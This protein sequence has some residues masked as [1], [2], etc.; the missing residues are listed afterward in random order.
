MASSVYTAASAAIQTTDEEIL[1]TNQSI[2]PMK[3]SVHRPVRQQVD[4]QTPT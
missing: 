1:E 3:S 4:T 2:N